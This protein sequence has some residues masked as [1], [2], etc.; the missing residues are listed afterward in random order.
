MRHPKAMRRK[1]IEWMAEFHR[2]VLDDVPLW[3][4]E[5]VVTVRGTR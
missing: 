2:Q 5:Q 4:R 1:T 3:M